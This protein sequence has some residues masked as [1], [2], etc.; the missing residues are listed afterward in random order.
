MTGFLEAYQGREIANL[1]ASLRSALDEYQQSLGQSELALALRLG[2]Q[3]AVRQAL[4]IIGDESAEVPTRLT[5]LE[6]LGQLKESRLVGQGL[7]LLGSSR[8]PAIKR[9]ALE[10]LMNFDDARIGQTICSR[11]HTTLPAE[12]DLRATAHR[13]LASR[14]EWTRQFLEEIA[15]FRI[16]RQTI[17]LD[18]VQQMRL[19]DDAAI[20]SALDQLWGRTRATPAEKQQQIARLQSLLARGGRQ[21]P[22]GELPLVA[23][24]E[25]FKKHCGVCHTLFDAGGQTGPN[26]TGYERTNL[27]FLLLAVVDPSAAIREEFTQFKVLTT[28]GRVL[29]GLIDAQTPTTVTLRGADNQT[30]LVNRDDIELLQAMETSLMPDGLTEKLTDAELRA[31][32]AYVMS[33]TPPR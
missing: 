29:T 1:P 8:S 18:I 11:Y 21:S 27:D 14:P 16:D 31:L 23:G 30:T 22:N 4:R 5:Y 20:Q 24:R 2:N 12:H 26:L 10:A 13:V 19:H 33:R 9:A 25:L 17:P 28:D 7:T 3:D 6:I 15:T 32:F